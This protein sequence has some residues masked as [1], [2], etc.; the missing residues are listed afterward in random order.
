MWPLVAVSSLLGLLVGSFLNVVIW[1]VPRGESIASP[2][3][4]CPGCDTPIAHRDNIP[5]LS[6]VLLR[7]RCRTCGARISGRYPAVE[8]TT[9]VLFA[10]TTW[11]LLALEHG[12]AVPAF[13]YLV[14]VSVALA[15]IDVDTGRLPVVI[16][17]PSIVVGAVLLAI[18]SFGEGDWSAMVRALAGL[19]ALYA[20]YLTLH[21]VKPR[22]MGMGDVR[23]SALIGLYLGW[24]GWGEL[25][26][27]AFLAFVLGGVL[28]MV[29]AFLTP[30]WEKDRVTLPDDPPPT[31]PA[32]IAPAP[33]P[34]AAAEPAT[35][36]RP[37]LKRRIPYGPYMLAGCL[38]GVLAGQEIADWYLSIM[39]P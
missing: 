13:L 38:L 14:A 15:L 39:I 24:L 22:G 30:D 33:T 32:G 18:A 8:L 34:A 5:V 35:A 7:A 6:W 3:S 29:Q 28:G 17:R 11:R 36:A 4:H 10:A 16:V 37:V 26:A 23:L 20:F 25:L 12:W 31:R 27:G 1:R 21:I 9:A 19:A 2:A